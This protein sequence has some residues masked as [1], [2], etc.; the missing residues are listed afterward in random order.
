MNANPDSLPDADAAPT[1]GS[2]PAAKPVRRRRTVK[3]VA[4][5][6]VEVGVEKVGETVVISEVAA[7]PEAGTQAASVEPVEPVDAVPKPRRRKVAV[8]QAVVEAG[9]RKSVV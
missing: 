5:P 7:A 4:E 3:A 1:E 2:E 8:E 6:G 9:D